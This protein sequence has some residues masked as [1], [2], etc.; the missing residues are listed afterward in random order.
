MGGNGTLFCIAHLSAN[1]SSLKGCDL[2]SG[3]WEKSKE[4]YISTALCG[5]KSSG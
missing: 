1:R 2:S 4:R 5:L 3:L